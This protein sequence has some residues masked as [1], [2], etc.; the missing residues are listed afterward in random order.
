MVIRP[1]TRVPSRLGVLGWLLWCPP[2]SPT[3]T[4]MSLVH[5][6]G[7]LLVRR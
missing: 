3:H 1:A 6:D 5:D 4:N 2:S 7:R